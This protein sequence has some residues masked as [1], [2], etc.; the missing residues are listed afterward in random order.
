MPVI[1]VIMK[2]TRQCVRKKLLFKHFSSIGWSFF[3]IHFGYVKNF[4]YLCNMK[5]ILLLITYIMLSL[6]CVYANSEDALL[7]TGVSVE[8]AKYRFQNISDLH[9]S[10]SFV[11]P[12]NKNANVEGNERI[13][14]ML[15]KKSDVI[16]DFRES[17]DKIH[18][19]MLNGKKCDYAFW[20][21]HIV[22]PGNKTKKGKN[23]VDISFTAGNQSLNRRDGYVYTL[24]VPDRARTVFPCFDQPDM[25]ARFTLS[26]QI[27]E[28]WVAVSNGKD[29]A[30]PS[31][32]LQGGMR[33]CQFNE[34]EP[35]STYLFAFAAGEFKHA[36]YTD[37]DMTISAYHRE[38]DSKRLAQ[39]D[40]IFKQVMFSIRW[41]EQYTGIAYPFQKYDLV[42]LPGFQ[43]GGMEHTGATFYNDNTL[44]LP[45]NPTPDERLRRTELIAHETSHM[46]FGDAVTMKWFDDVWTKEVF[47]N[48]FA[49]EI[50]APLF[51]EINHD[52]NWL[53]TYTAAAIAQ[54]RTDGRT[55]IRQPLDNLRNAGLIY[56]NIIYNKAPVM[57]RL[58]VEKM[59]K[60]NFRR[61]IQKYLKKHLYGNADWDDLIRIL[62]SETS[63][64]LKS[65][66]NKWVDK[67]EYPHFTAET[68]LDNRMGQRYGFTELTEEQIDSLMAY[69]PTEKNA[70]ARQ[71]LLMTLE[72]NYLAKNI[73]NNE[74]IEFLI[75]NLIDETDY[76]TASTIISYLREPMLLLNNKQHIETY[77]KELLTLT[78][79]HKL[80]ACR[81]EVFRLLRGIMRTKV[82]ID[83]LYTI[84]QKKSESYS[85]N[86][87]TTLAYELAIR[88]PDKAQN[89]LKQQRARIKNSDRL[90]QFDF[91][92]RAV[93]SSVASRDQLFKSLS[94][95]ENRRIEPWT[96]SVLYYLNHPLRDRESVRYIQPA[97]QMLPEIQQTGD[98]FF[99]ASWCTNLLSGHRSNAAYKE[100]E[101]FLENNPD[102]MP[103]LRNKILT[104][105]Y[106]LK[107]A[108]QIKK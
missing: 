70:T 31:K 23:V 95:P 68:C 85:E 5:R 15:K 60:A 84:W 101:T 48:Y 56:N 32:T 67:A 74:W 71:A 53:K 52:L 10:L 79:H 4:L 7:E 40:D 96:L 20:N 44:F 13:T 76:L 27:P 21:E 18:S 41:Q 99:P 14:F 45:E 97:L 12:E 92:S 37:G 2:R 50:T 34:T 30:K 29:I 36:T 108:N 42:I 105:E 19:V 75:D 80:K 88:K 64:N 6:G 83:K 57:M 3:F 47:A 78:Q 61:G 43:F 51:P 98:I 25:K 100:V 9:Y 89:I 8:L 86:D 55:S 11:I 39:L 106:Y 77:E 24:F 90:S 72:E 62:D 91:I 82:V 81:I 104:A 33:L 26:L 63:T 54:D 22:I 58:I 93:N 87:Y 38:T 1:L 59:G 103:L 73:G 66:S 65:F 35:L 69:W 49:A 107:R 46:W 28:R 17:K 94:K 102:L 16:L